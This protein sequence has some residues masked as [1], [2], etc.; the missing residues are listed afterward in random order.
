M[1]N[2]LSKKSFY[3]IINYA[4]L[5]CYANIL[6][7]SF[8][9]LFQ[10]IVQKNNNL[11][12][13]S[14]INVII[15]NFVIIEFLFAMICFSVYNTKAY[16]RFMRFH[17]SM[18]CY[19]SG[20]L[21]AIFILGISFGASPVISDYVAP[22][23]Q[24]LDDK[25][26]NVAKKVDNLVGAMEYHDLQA[27]FSD[28]KVENDNMIFT[29]IPSVEL[30]NVLTD[31]NTHTKE[32]VSI[33]TNNT[34]FSRLPYHSIQ[35]VDMLGRNDYI[36]PDGTTIQNNKILAFYS[37]S[38]DYKT[39]Y[40]KE[41]QALSFSLYG[42]QNEC[43]T[44]MI[45]NHYVESKYKKEYPSTESHPICITND[46]HNSLY[47][48]S[49][50]SQREVFRQQILIIST[51][52]TTI[53]SDRDFSFKISDIHIRGLQN[54]ESPNEA[55]P[56]RDDKPYDSFCIEG[57]HKG[58]PDRIIHMNRGNARILAGHCIMDNDQYSSG[59]KTIE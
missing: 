52:D 53:Y 9:L 56:F 31:V 59:K 16:H 34:S 33:P 40:P 8:V 21:I 4:I 28:H 25:L 2:I 22:V 46:F 18:I 10:T 48:L 30:S 38:F 50:D 17:K 41:R 26:Q 23:N 44:M 11:T 42:K 15:I 57:F 1:A 3:V 39:L 58:N 43:F 5:V 19:I 24:K 20:I 29:F 51:T 55:I 35:D 47:Y 32:I 49:L 37:I 13:Q 6:I 45:I 7:F 27:S 36:T 54:H 14:L 12:Y